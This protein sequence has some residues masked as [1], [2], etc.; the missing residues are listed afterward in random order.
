MKE[1]DKAREEKL[2]ENP[3]GFH[4]EGS[5]SC[6]ICGDGTPEGDN[7]YDKWGIKCLVCQS[8]IDK[9]EVPASIAKN[10]D[11]WYSKY[12]IES[13]FNIKGPTFYKWVRQ[14]IIKPR[15]I[16]RYGK[17][18]HYQIFMVK[19]NEDTL[20]PKK[21]TESQRGTEMID[22][23]KHDSF[24]PWYRFAGAREKVQK[25]KIMDHLKWVEIPQ[26]ETDTE[27]A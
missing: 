26:N 2:K 4:L 11:S 15:I 9:G 12:D 19:D 25:Y 16:T 5:Y 20:P 1:K 6:T 3:K 27:S 13:R 18:E 23:K 17:G 8:A 22:G 24:F 14:G 7:W 10:K 21:L